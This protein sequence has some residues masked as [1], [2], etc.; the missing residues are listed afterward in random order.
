MDNVSFSNEKYLNVLLDETYA[1]ISRS[2]DA[3]KKAVELVL[4]HIVQYTY[5]IYVKSFAKFYTLFVMLDM[6][7]KLTPAT[8]TTSSSYWV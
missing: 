2:I 3:H 7:I 8:C 6:W 5:N 1:K 4:L